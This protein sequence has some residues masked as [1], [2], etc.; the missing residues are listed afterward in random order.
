M[1]E[2]NSIVVSKIQKAKEEFLQYLFV[3]IQPIIRENRKNFKKLLTSMINEEQ[4]SST[5]RKSGITLNSAKTS[6]EFF[7]S[8]SL[9]ECLPNEVDF[10][11]N[12]IFKLDKVIYRRLGKRLDKV[13]EISV[14]YRKEVEELIKG[15]LNPNSEVEMNK[16]AIYA[17]N[18]KA[19]IS[20]I[21]KCF[22]EE[23]NSYLSSSISRIR[24]YINSKIVIKRER[25]LEIEPIELGET[26]KEAEIKKRIKNNSKRLVSIMA[27]FSDKEHFFNYS[28]GSKKDFS[29]KILKRATNWDADSVLK[30]SFNI[31]LENTF[32]QSTDKQKA[33]FLSFCLKPITKSKAKSRK[34]REDEY[35]YFYVANLNTEGCDEFESKIVNVIYKFGTDISRKEIINVLKE[36]YKQIKGI[37]NIEFPG[38]ELRI[39]KEITKALSGLVFERK[40]HS[41]F[42]DIEDK[43][44]IRK[45]FDTLH[46]DTSIRILKSFVTL[47]R[48]I[49]I[50]LVDY[51]WIKE[52][53]E[54]LSELQLLE[55][56]EWEYCGD[57]FNS[58]QR[59]LH[60]TMFSKQFV[61]SFNKKPFSFDIK[62]RII[63]KM[64]NKRIIDHN[65]GLVLYKEYEKLNDEQ[66][67]VIDE[68]CD[69]TI[70][71]K[72]HNHNI[73]DINGIC[74]N[75]EQLNGINNKINTIEFL[76]LLFIEHPN[77]F[78]Q[79][80]FVMFHDN[81][82]L[83]KRNDGT[84][85]S[86]FPNVRYRQFVLRRIDDSSSEIKQME[87]YDGSEV[88]RVSSIINDIFKALTQEVFNNDS[89]NKFLDKLYVSI[90]VRFINDD[91]LSWGIIDDT[92]KDCLNMFFKSYK[93][94]FPNI[95]SE[96]KLCVKQN[97]NVD[98]NNLDQKEVI[99]F[100]DSQKEIII[101]DKIFKLSLE[102]VLAL[103]RFTSFYSSILLDRAFSVIYN[104]DVMDNL[105]MKL[106][107]KEALG[108][109]E[110]N[111]TIKHFKMRG[112]DMT[113]D[114]TLRFLFVQK[115]MDIVNNKP[116][117]EQVKLFL[118]NFISQPKEVIMRNMLESGHNKNL[119]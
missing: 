44:Q 20:L 103:C 26:E 113:E 43:T 33:E 37:K 50:E 51:N 60:E 52:I 104:R 10:R 56:F 81:L 4:I 7:M 53:C 36:D 109:V 98:L 66:L 88:N 101:T 9:I 71:S 97:Q 110:I 77:A 93:F 45:I 114:K 86:L 100:L 102:D 11:F 72:E 79:A 74:I 115:F 70:L 118:N 95:L 99:F 87:D 24:N 108:V 90:G 94:I 116:I 29:K 67:N 32:P 23:M 42:E 117:N 112:K 84:I 111:S 92:T 39:E 55:E 12:P 47:F 22:E 107:F 105:E 76:N 68:L 54:N 80:D 85:F 46:F 17:N 49:K 59:N 13:F 3:G 6:P 30:E 34:E 15:Q 19:H 57:S 89:G 78:N 65:T 96:I 5:I 106:K 91:K 31:V 27:G 21:G 73:I 14:P 25:D 61:S 48:T 58:S 119:D 41:Y 82:I 16:S 38:T 35:R 69:A 28:V 2:G 18:L 8:L 40:I 62:N 83:V 1:N 63:H 64:F 75:D